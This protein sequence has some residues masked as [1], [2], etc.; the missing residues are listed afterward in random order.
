MLVP[1]LVVCMRFLALL[2]PIKKP[3]ETITDID[4]LGTLV[5]VHS[6]STILIGVQSSGFANAI[7]VMIEV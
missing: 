1:N 2:N 4:S 7:P 6:I 3:T 5:R